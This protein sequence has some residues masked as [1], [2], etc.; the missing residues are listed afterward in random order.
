MNSAED[1][2]LPSPTSAKAVKFLLQSRNLAPNKRYGQNFLI[3]GPV[4]EKIVH[5][6]ECEPGDRVLEIGPGLGVLTEALLN[7]G[8]EVLA[9]EIDRGLAELLRER[10]RGKGG[11]TVIQA[12]AL[13]ADWRRVAQE[14]WQAQ[15]NKVAA[16][17]PYSITG[18]IVARLLKEMPETRLWVLMVQQEVAERMLAAPGNKA[19]GSFSVL[20]Q[21]YTQLELVQRVSP[22]SFYPQPKVHSSVIRLRRKDDL[23]SNDI[24][25]DFERVVRSLFVFRRKTLRKALH[26]WLG[27]YGVDADDLLAEV[28]LDAQRRAESL[29]IGEFLQLTHAIRD[30]DILRYNHS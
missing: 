8:A 23:P 15:P 12:D 3:D 25:L 16:N 22:S 27:D 20:V 10:L 9:V 21:F 28:K 24:C 6:A 1:H 7:E 11:L 2:S 19:Y 14:I 30:F 29:R 13:E 26:E 4:V 18:P 5:A 17:L